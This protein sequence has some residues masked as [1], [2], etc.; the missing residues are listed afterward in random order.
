M[1]I[2]FKPVIAARIGIG[3]LVKNSTVGVENQR[4]FIPDYPM[5]IL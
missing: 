2:I 3:K 1:T 5:D 4:L